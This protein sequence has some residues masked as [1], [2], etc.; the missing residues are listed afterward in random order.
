MEKAVVRTRILRKAIERKEIYETT[1]KELLQPGRDERS[2]KKPKR[3]NCGRMEWSGIFFVHRA[4]QKEK[5]IRSKSKTTTL[6]T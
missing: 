6:S 3:N 2:G 4:E 5:C 1:H